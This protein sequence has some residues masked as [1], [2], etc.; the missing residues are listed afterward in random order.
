MN[1]F[2]RELYRGRIS[3]WEHRLKVNTKEKT[4]YDNIKTQKQYFS[5]I[6]SDEDFKKIE[7]LEEMYQDAQCIN[8][9]NTFIQ[10]LR[11]G[12]LFMCAIFTGEEEEK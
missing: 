9:E 5:E 1:I 10:A 2:L 11:F 8:D 3:G 12:V 4:I 6:L 7:A